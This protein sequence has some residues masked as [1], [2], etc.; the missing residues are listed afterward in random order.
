MTLLVIAF[1]PIPGGGVL[2]FTIMFSTLGIPT[3]ALIMVTAVEIVSEFFATGSNIMLLLLEIACG[4]ARL[5]DL[6]RTVLAE[7]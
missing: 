2:V 1:P 7:N 5:G 3:E 4:A 6:D